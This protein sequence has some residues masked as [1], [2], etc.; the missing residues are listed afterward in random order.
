M[1]EKVG[2]LGTGMVG[3]GHASRL[4]RLGHEVSLGTRDSTSTLASRSGSPFADWHYANPAV[5]MRNFVE[6]VEGAEIVISALNGL[7]AV[8]VL[9]AI[10]PALRGKVLIDISNPLDFSRG[11]PPTLSVCN[12]HS[13]GERI[14]LALPETRVV[15]TLNTMNVD[16]QI[17]PRSLGDGD[18]TVFLSGND[19]QAKSR[20]TEILSDW[21]GW[22]NPID[23][24][25]RSTARGTEMMMPIWLRLMSALGTSAFNFK[26]VR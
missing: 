17:D 6:A 5:T 20:V 15:K 13:P 12:D 25:D 9:R 7:V 2:V 18:H 8:E 22:R 11:M 10:E 16:L 1:P 24:G 19:E 4:A 14:Q 23:L 3:R 26:V 21:Y